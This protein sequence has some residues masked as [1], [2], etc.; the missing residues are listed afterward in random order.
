MEALLHALT[1]ERARRVQV[2]EALQNAHEAIL[3]LE[4]QVARREAE[5]ESRDHQYI[6]DVKPIPPKRTVIEALHHS[7]S[8]MPISEVVRSLSAAEEHNHILKLEINELSDRVSCP[9]PPNY[10]PNAIVHVTETEG[11]PEP[12]LYLGRGPDSASGIRS[13]AFSTSPSADDTYTCHAFSERG[14]E[15]RWGP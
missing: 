1:V 2:S 11:Y 15:Q 14:R 5:L 8:E 7:P 3:T 10:S 12:M 9:P 4:A 6:A 13:P